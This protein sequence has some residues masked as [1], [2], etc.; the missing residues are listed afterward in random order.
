MKIGRLTPVC[1][2]FFLIFHII[3]YAQTINQPRAMAEWEEL[4]GIVIAWND[5]SYV[6]GHQTP[7]TKAVR[8]AEMKTLAEITRTVLNEGL[9]IYILDTLNSNALVDLDS[10]GI[11]SPNIEIMEFSQGNYWIDVWLRDRGP[12]S[13]YQNE[14]DSLHFVYWDDNTGA[15]L[16]ANHMNIPFINN[17]ILNNPY[18]DG[19]NYMTDGHGRVFSD[20]QSLN[21]ALLPA[22]Q[23][24][25]Q[26]NM[27][28]TQLFNL[29][30]YRVHIDYYM[31]LIDEETIL[32]SDIP[33]S[34]YDPSV[35]WYFQDNQDIQ[36]A[37]DYISNNY[38]SCYGRPYKFI[39]ITNAPTINLFSLN[40]TAF[41]RDL[42]YVNSLILNNTIIIPS[43]D[44]LLFGQMA[45]YEQFDVNARTIYEQVMP[46]Y[47][48]VSVPSMFFGQRGGTVHCITK[49]IGSPEPIRITH[50]WLPDTVHNDGN[51]Y[52]IVSRV[53]TR[54]GVQNVTL[55]YSIDPNSGFL[56]T[57]MTAAG[58][59][60][61][62]AE[63]P[64]QPA[65]T[66]MY[67]YFAAQ[68]HSGKSITKPIVGSQGPYS[69]NI[70]SDPTSID[71]NLAKLPPSVIL[72]QN[73]PNPFNPVTSISWRLTTPGP[74]KLTIYNL[75]GQEVAILVDEE[76]AAGAHSIQVDA[77]G[78]ASGIYLYRLQTGYEDKIRK[79]T[80]MK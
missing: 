41:T 72:H 54:S 64:L 17:N 68:S 69:F 16:L 79:M 12:M 36:A 19:G 71:E 74:V 26:N 32:V 49:E 67:Y 46:G 77:S 52:D 73:Y 78:L 18:T 31:K 40:L 43:F 2:I 7:L 59:D 13:V 34:N 55:Y 39:R 62:V 22:I 1:A 28:V 48:I 3:L 29:P 14:V 44:S 15:E 8:K 21:P 80:L 4:Q 11:S 57:P 37:I 20:G 50:K 6:P 47:N 42:S 45:G 76:Q 60:S 61:F 51:P 58:S 66:T 27:G 63:I 9:Q 25:Y 24:A 33:Y 10:F 30:P 5:F 23:S 56:N 70:L 53:K 35:D 38:L 75:T 65:G